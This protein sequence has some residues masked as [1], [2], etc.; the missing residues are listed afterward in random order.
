MN[1]IAIYPGRF[2]PFGKHHYEA[3][4]WLVSKFGRSNTFIATSGVVDLDKS[5]FP[6]ELKQK[7]IAEYGVPK[8]QIIKTKNPYQAVELVSRYNDKDTAVVFMYGSKDLGRIKLNKK[9]GTPRYF[10]MY[11]EGQDLLPYTEKGYIIVA[12]HISIDVDGQEMSGTALRAYLKNATPDQFK[13]ATGWFDQQ[14][15]SQVKTI[16]NPLTKEGWKHFFEIILQEETATGGAGDVDDGPRFFHGNLQSYKNRSNKYAKAI[17]DYT[18]LNWIVDDDQSIPNHGTDFPK[19]PIDAVSF[20]PSGRP[21]GQSAGTDYADDK[22][23]VEGY[24]A[25]KN[26]IQNIANNSG[27][28]IEDFLDA[29]KSAL[30]KYK[31]EEGLLDEQ[32]ISRSQL[33]RIE[34]YVRE[35]N[36]KQFKETVFGKPKMIKANINESRKLLLCGG[37]AGHMMHPFDDLDITFKQMK[38]MIYQTLSGKL[39]IKSAVTEKIDGQNLMVTY[40]DGKVGAARNKGTILNPMDISQVRSKFAGRGEIEKAFTGAMQ[41]LETA[42]KALPPQTLEKVFKNGRVFLN[43]EIVFPGTKNVIDYGPS[44]SLIFHG[45]VEFDD[46]ANQVG[47]DPGAGHKLHS[48]IDKVNA[49]QQQSF[50]ITKPQAVALKKVNQY[51]SRKDELMRMLY[52]LQKD[53]NLQDSS[54]LGDYYDAFWEEFL[55]KQYPNMDPQNKQQLI[56]RW[57]RGTKASRISPQLYG[58][59]AA[60]LIDIDKTLVPEYNGKIRSQFEHLFLRLGVLV[61]GSV[62]DLLAVNPKQATA[63]IRKEIL[64]TMQKAKATDNVADFQKAVVNLQKLKQLGGLSAIVPSEGLVF[65]YNGKLYKLTGAF[66]PINQILGLFRF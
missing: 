33:D 43:L 2:Q 39:S 59:D 6:F 22:Q 23:G 26:Y 35:I 38:D 63:T 28:N 9:D 41:D 13:K 49:S 16:L 5:P 57:A 17:G 25:W 3:Y 55:N 53:Y 42:L 14:L 44:A 37:A 61:L 46:N 30:V 18:V 19:G 65:P 12:P 48:L 40:K 51:S 34:K 10:A 20:F 32:Y 21:T 15:Y 11:E 29:D 56:K 50:E 45:T 62:A 1:I 60:E 64:A 8:N 36:G 52:K 31:L 27:L 47:V 7:F 66:A 54:T 4:K 24:N 58:Q